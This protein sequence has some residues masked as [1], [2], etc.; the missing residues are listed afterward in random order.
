MFFVVHFD[1]DVYHP[2]SLTIGISEVFGTLIYQSHLH[3]DRTVH[4]QVLR[5]CHMMD[6]KFPHQ[7]DHLFSDLWGPVPEVFCKCWHSPRFSKFARFLAVTDH[8]SPTHYISV[9]IAS[10][11][12]VYFLATS[13]HTDTKIDRD[14]CVAS[15][16]LN[17]DLEHVPFWSSNTLFL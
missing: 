17:S 16:P 3:F 15:I 12:T 7:V 4:V 2:V 1:S 10:L 8:L 9:P 11:S 5:G 6:I 13:H 14:L